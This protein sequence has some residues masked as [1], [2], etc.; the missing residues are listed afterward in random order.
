M[1]VVDYRQMKLLYSVE[2]TKKNFP[3]SRFKKNSEVMFNP[4]IF[5]NLHLHKKYPTEI[6]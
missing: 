1:L 6:N 3:Q 4:E 2:K 5:Q